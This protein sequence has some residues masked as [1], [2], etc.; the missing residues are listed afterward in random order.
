MKKYWVFK[1]SVIDCQFLCKIIVFQA[2]WSEM[3]EKELGF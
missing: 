1:Y 2:K 3:Y